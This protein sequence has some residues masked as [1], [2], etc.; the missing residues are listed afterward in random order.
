[1][2]IGVITIHHVT[3]YGAVMQNYALT[4]ALASHGARVETIDY[5]PTIAV[6]K[7][8]PKFFKRGVPAVR[9]FLRY[10]AFQHFID[11]YLPLSESTYSTGQELRDSVPF[12]DVLVCGSDQI[13]CVGAGSF[14]GYDPNFFLDIGAGPSVRKFSYAAS[15]GD[16]V[17][18]AG[19][20]AAI[21]KALAGFTGIAVRD[22]HTA[23]LIHRA[24]GRAPVV[25]LDPVFL[26]DFQELVGDVQ[27][28]DDLVVFS[29]RPD[30]L[31]GTARALADEFG[32]RVVA[33]VH[34]FRGADLCHRVVS[35][36]DW[37]RRLSGARAVLTD[38][39]HG[40]A[41]SLRFGRPVM[42][43]PA[44]GKVNKIQDLLKRVGMES[45]QFDPTGPMKPAPLVDAIRN[46]ETYR[47]SL[48]TRLAGPTAVSHDYLRR[49]ASGASIAA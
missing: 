30:R 43:D 4:R 26:H 27:Q 2:R 22:E 3:N 36:V 1:M 46:P 15:A 13:W 32:L 25:V 37:L 34:P 49:I 28:S 31:A 20:T 11:T 6:K 24:T 35:P 5:R 29:S 19:H 23:G 18:F 9:A 7:Y 39:F 48:Q 33:L 38:Y 44:P 10:R 17:D 14:R 41:V 42:V 21:T 8:K 40:L 12:Y 16:T 45:F 47:A